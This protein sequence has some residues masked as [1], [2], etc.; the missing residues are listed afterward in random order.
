MA[1]VVVITYRA[2]I[3]EMGAP[4]TEVATDIE[5]NDDGSVKVV[6]SWVKPAIAGDEDSVPGGQPL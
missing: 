1:A 6:V 4:P 3:A 5:R 2:R